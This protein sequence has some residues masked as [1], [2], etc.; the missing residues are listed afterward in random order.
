MKKAF[1]LSILAFLMAGGFYVEN[2]KAQKKSK[3]KTVAASKGYQW[4][5]EWNVS[6]RYTPSALTIKMLPG[7]KFDFTIEALNGANM[8]EVSGVAKINGGKAFFDDRESTEKDA[9]KYGCRLTFTH[10]GDFIAV[11]ENEECSSYAGAGVVFAG[12]YAK[13]KPP[14]KEQNFVQRGV[15][16]SLAFDQK[17]KTLVAGNYENFLNAFHQIYDAPDLDNLNA[18][19]FAACVRGVCPWNAGIIMYDEK[20]NFWA[21]VLGVDDSE[22]TFVHYYTNVSS[23]VEKPPKTIEHWVADKRESNENLTVVYKNKK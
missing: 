13:G 4:S 8:G 3:S 15:F 9:D 21:A 5:G 16:P 6:S 14:V 1:V 12:N 19:V 11:E 10:K 22:K 17:F 20:Q 7:G 18:K 2:I 23:W